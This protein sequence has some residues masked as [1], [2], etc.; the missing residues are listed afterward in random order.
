MNE[1]DSLMHYGVKG[2]KWGVVKDSSSAIANQT[3]TATEHTNRISSGAKYNKKARH[4]TDE[5][6]RREIAR[7]ELEQRYSSLNPSTTSRGASAATNALSV[8]GSMAAVAA[9]VATVAL[10]VKEFKKP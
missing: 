9:S 4:M 10:A 8:I 2:M 7:L 3:K 6:L 5:E 1:K